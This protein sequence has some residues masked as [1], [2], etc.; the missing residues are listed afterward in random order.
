MEKAR[1]EESGSWGVSQSLNSGA[2]RN[3]NQVWANP[4]SAPTG[5]Q[6]QVGGSRLGNSRGYFDESGQAVNVSR[7]QNIG[8][9]TFY[10]RGSQWVDNLAESA[11]LKTIKI[12]QFSDAHFKLL[13]ASPELVRY[14]GLGNMR[15]MVNNQAI[16]IG[17]EGREDLSDAEIKSIVGNGNPS[18]GAVPSDGSGPWKASSGVVGVG[19]A[20]AAV[21]KMRA[22]AGS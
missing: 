3:Q 22:V 19:F 9:R 16:E 4:G 2:L 5:P 7:V 12:K 10:Q 11:S 20:L 1:M 15:V 6:G 17:S 14:Q 13:A 18:S 21:K 8:T